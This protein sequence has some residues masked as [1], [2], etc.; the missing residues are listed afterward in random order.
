MGLNEGS[1][2]VFFSSWCF[3]KKRSMLGL[4]Y[5]L[6]FLVFVMRAC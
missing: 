3:E 4:L 2:A 1:W 5:F 6:L